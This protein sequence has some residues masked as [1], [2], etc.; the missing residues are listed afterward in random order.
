MNPSSEPFPAVKAA[1]LLFDMDGTLVDSTA[2]VADLWTDF[3]REHG[4][5][6]DELLEYSHGRQT[7][8][9]LR[10]FL[11]GTPKELARIATDL[12]ARECLRLE[13][14]AEIPGARAFIEQLDGV[15][16]AVVT[17]AGRALAEIRLRA[18]GLP[19]PGVLVTAEDV[20]AGKPSPEGYLRAAAELGIDI[21]HCV[22][23]EDAPAGLQAAVTSGAT[24]VVVGTYE[25][26]LTRSLSRTQDYH[27]LV[28]R[29]GFLAGTAID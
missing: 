17:S 10:R 7:L 16:Y 5:D 6:V 8:D 23:F 9:T 1:A 12:E 14:I 25:S 2:V 28:Y 3:A 24:T 4:I 21:A 26:P 13:G 29:D 19:V 18:A 11:P 15:P 27:R 22:A 20:L